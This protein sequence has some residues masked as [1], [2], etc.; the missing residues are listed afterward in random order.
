MRIL[1]VE[2]DDISFILDEAVLIQHGDHDIDRSIDLESSMEMLQKHQYDLVL[3][4]IHL[5]GD[6]GTALV[7][8]IPMTTRIIFTTSDPNFAV[9]A[10]ELNALD[11]LV[12]PVS[13]ERFFCST[14]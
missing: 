2:D 10:F 14:A 3:L 5:G 13:D 4:D 6:E 12:K 11:Y 8:Y 9:E 7:D 1:I